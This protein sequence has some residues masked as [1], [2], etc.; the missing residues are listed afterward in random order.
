VALAALALC[1]SSAGMALATSRE[2]RLPLDGQ[3]WR[4]AEM[5]ELVALLGI[6]IAM[7]LTALSAVA[8]A[9]DTTATAYDERD[10]RACRN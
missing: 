7:L 10:T 1:A 3:H 2:W 8:S 9:G 6:A 5:L 4:L